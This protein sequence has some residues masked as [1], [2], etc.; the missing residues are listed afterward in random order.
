MVSKR[1]KKVTVKKSF[2]DYL[3]VDFDFVITDMLMSYGKQGYRKFKNYIETEIL[4]S[5]LRRSHFE[6]FNKRQ[7]SNL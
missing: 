2:F 1:K 4:P 5:L 6:G 7:V 3:K